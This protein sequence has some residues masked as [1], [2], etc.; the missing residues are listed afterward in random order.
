MRRR[1][2]ITPLGGG[3]GAVLRSRFLMQIANLSD[4]P[5]LSRH[6][7]RKSRRIRRNRL[8]SQTNGPKVPG[9]LGGDRDDLVDTPSLRSGRLLCHRGFLRRQR[10]GRSFRAGLYDGQSEHRR[11]H[12][13][14]CRARRSGQQL[15]Q[16][17]AAVWSGWPHGAVRRSTGPA[18]AYRSFARRWLQLYAS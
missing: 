4:A 8:C 18:G 10:L 11:E 12:H 17:R 15:R 3:C 16:G 1:R 6:T 5:W 14:V 13:A 7:F 2:F 9:S